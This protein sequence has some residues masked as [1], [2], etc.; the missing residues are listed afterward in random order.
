[1]TEEN[2]LSGQTVS[3]YR[4]LERL[5][6]GGMGV[7]YKAE[8]TR[9]NRFVALKFLPEEVAKGPQ[10]LTRF[11][12]E[13]QAASALNHPN[14]CT[15]YDIGE[16]Q[17]YAFLAMELLEGATLRHLIQSGPL[18]TGQ[19]LDLA[20]EL[21]EALDAAHAK[22][23]LHRDFK[24]ANIFVTERGHA[25]L[26]DF[27]LAKL[28][29]K[30][31]VNPGETTGATVDASEELLTSPGTAVGTM[32]YMSPEQVRGEKLDARTDLF[33]LGVV[34]YEMATG[35][36][37][38][39]GDTS[40]LTFEAILNRQPAPPV[41]LNPQIPQDLDRIIVKLLEKDRNLRYQSAAEVRTDLRRLKR[42][43][44]SGMGVSPVAAVPRR[45]PLAKILGI[46]M[47]ITAVAAAFFIFRYTEHLAPSA[48]KWEQLTFFSDSA[49]YP[50]L[51]PDGKMLA[52]IRGNDTFF[53]KGQIY[54]KMLSAGEPVQLT[55]DEAFKLSPVFSPDDSRISYGTTDPWETWEVPVLG[56]EPRRLLA[57]A[58]SLTW[59]GDGRH[60]LFSETKSG[61][62]MGV[63]TSDET[64]GQSRDVYTP[65]GERSMAH[66]S[67]LSP[68]GHWV[69]VVVMGNKGEMLP[70]R[71]VPFDGSGAEQIVGPP[72]ASCTTGSWSPDG[73]WV[74][75][76]SNKGG[77]FHI[78]RQRFPNG[79]LEQVTSG[80]TEE[81]GIAMA[82]DG[83]S[84]L[85]SVGSF[86]STL[87]LHDEKGDHQL[88]S[89]GNVFEPSLSPDG[90]KLYY[91]LQSGE[92]SD[93]ELWVR[94]LASG[95]KERLL[96]AFPILSGVNNPKHYAVSKDGNYVV[97]ARKEHGDNSRL[98]LVPT[99][100]H[101]P[102][103]QIPSTASEDSPFFLPDGEVVFRS[104]EGALN[105]I[106]REN[107]NGT[108]RRKILPSP[109]LELF[110]VS[111]DGRWVLTGGKA[112]AEQNLSA[113]I[114]A[115]VEGGP[116]VLA[117]DTFCLG[118]WDIHGKS[119]FLRFVGDG[120]Q[121]TYFL[122]LNDS[123][124]LP[125]LPAARSITPADF[126]ANRKVTVVPR[127]LETAASPDFYAYTQQ[128][129]R[130]NIY[131][132]FLP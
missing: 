4:I 79:Q 73:K 122:P 36:R 74:Y 63:V 8:D 118:N 58:S 31:L 51:S 84:L 9:L 76:S 130:R 87:W 32:A 50:A 105:F 70:C 77:R 54:V 22:G 91:L 10:A 52:F 114:F 83:K 61:I 93:V 106:Y 65:A 109:I 132:I 60:L 27:G 41:R 35:K 88:S 47:G 66:H 19:I 110:A 102:P 30:H 53:G 95:R 107:R 115:P 13:A 44:E 33:S 128:N 38:F 46:A 123:S 99:D 80:P 11:Q 3:H 59:I 71:V 37:P 24:P 126:K 108:A 5:G 85:T 75:V 113:I 69:L 96:E 92:S 116:T 23:V 25:K 98:W 81:E 16:D 104:T 62:H 120:G 17:G 111:T 43:S 72:D 48:A 42:D 2:F 90:S 100:H 82:P 117:C 57:N 103:F 121:S 26:L 127:A 28:F 29:G 1:M 125:D 78:W 86:D 49:V 40:G 18:K 131:R 15:I 39:A 97:F 129:V 55:H 68:D 34:L 94:E 64:R 12:R 7:V 56:G 124:G 20:I 6:G 45:R 89:E 119:L 14:I 112:P 101:A 67:Y 21:T